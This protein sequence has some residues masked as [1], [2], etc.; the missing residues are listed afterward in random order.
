MNIFWRFV[1]A[2]LILAG[3]GRG[4]WAVVV[5]G[6]VP[7][8]LILPPAIAFMAGLPWGRLIAAAVFLGGVWMFCRYYPGGSARMKAQGVEIIGDLGLV[9]DETGQSVSRVMT[10][11]GP[12]QNEVCMQMLLSPRGKRIRVILNYPV[13]AGTLVSFW[14]PKGDRGMMMTPADKVYYENL[15]GERSLHEVGPFRF[16]IETCLPMGPDNGSRSIN[17]APWATTGRPLRVIKYSRY[18]TLEAL[19]PKSFL[20][21]IKFIYPDG[22]GPKRLPSIEEVGVI[23]SIDFCSSCNH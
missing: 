8:A 13:E 6:I 22:G 23:K 5:L 21:G 14:R 3:V 10:R 1:V 19:G 11:K 9:V 4:N 17:S 16:L 15:P 12:R 20:V 2:G 7:L 18:I